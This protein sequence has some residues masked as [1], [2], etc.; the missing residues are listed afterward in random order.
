MAQL[1]TLTFEDAKLPFDQAFGY[2]SFSMI[3]FGVLR[4]NNDYD[5][6]HMSNSKSRE[7]VRIF[8]TI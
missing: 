8:Y 4:R 2:R 1:K 6:N 5:M 3:T 7:S